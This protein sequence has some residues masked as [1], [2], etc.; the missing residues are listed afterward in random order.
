MRILQYANAL[1]LSLALLPQ[2]GAAQAM[3]SAPVAQ[4]AATKQEPPAAEAKATWKGE[5]YML[6]TCAASGRPLDVKNS[7]TTK[8]VENQELKFCCNGCADAVA[9]DPAKWVEKVNAAHA[10][11]QRSIYPMT[12]CVVTGEPLVDE[13]GKDIATEVVIQ[14]RLFR[15]CCGDCTKAVKADPGKF[16]AKLDA[17]ALEAQAKTYPLTHCVNNPKA[18]V[19]A[20]S[21]Q[22]VVAGRLVRTCCGKC[23]AKVVENPYDYVMAVDAARA[24]AAKGGGAPVEAGTK[25][26]DKKGE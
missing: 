25:Q 17:A 19:T 4:D 14:N 20:E 13:A 15:L 22:F 23:K 8:V 26:G 18:A 11:Q 24:A 2:L 21:T 9:K 12:T 5:P 3:L 1:C 16:A 7:R 6:A 10:D